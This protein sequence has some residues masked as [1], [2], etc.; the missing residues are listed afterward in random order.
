MER[1]MIV[2]ALIMYF[3]VFIAS[4]VKFSDKK[5]L[6]IFSAMLSAFVP[7]FLIMFWIHFSAYVWKKDLKKMPMLKMISLMFKTLLIEIS[8]IPVMHTGIIWLVIERIKEHK[9]SKMTFS[10]FRDSELGDSPLKRLHGELRQV[11]S[12]QF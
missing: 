1:K 4:L 11:V 7:F 12:A 8:M 9:N 3:A 2:A 10:V 5:Q 6:N